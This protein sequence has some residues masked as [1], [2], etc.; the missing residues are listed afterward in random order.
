MRLTCGAWL[1]HCAARKIQ[2]NMPI[3][4]VIYYRREGSLLMLTNDTREILCLYFEYTVKYKVFCSS[5]EINK[6]EDQSE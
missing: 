2:A 6:P 5:Q 1:I 3:S 4:P